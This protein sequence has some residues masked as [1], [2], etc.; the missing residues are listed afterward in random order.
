MPGVDLVIRAA[1]ADPAALA[2]CLRAGAAG[3]LSSGGGEL[4][5]VA[6]LRRVRGREAVVDVEIHRAL[7]GAGPRARDHDALHERLRPREQ[8]VLVLLA[9]GRGTREIAET[10]GLSRN[11]VRSYAQALMS[12]LQVHNRVQLVVAAR[13]LDLG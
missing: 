1:P 3:I 12:K 8:E 2:A 4:D 6:G 10:L 11:T 9:E 7:H 5:L 13:R